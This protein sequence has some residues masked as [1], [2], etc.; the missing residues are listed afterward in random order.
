MVPLKCPLRDRDD[1][2][3][4]TKVVYGMIGCRPTTLPHSG[5]L[6]RLRVD[7]C[8][9]DRHPHAGRTIDDLDLGLHLRAS[10]WTMLVRRP[11]PW[12]RIRCRRHCPKRPAANSSR[13]FRSAPSPQRFGSARGKACFTALMTSSE[14]I[15][16]RLTASDE[17]ASPTADSTFSEITLWSP[18]I[19][20]THNGKILCTAFAV[21]QR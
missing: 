19:G 9:C 16:P 12:R 7:G 6:R 4:S 13:K 15:S 1:T 18:I 3:P 10:T 2:R 5:N 17:R 14:T 21:H 20:G 8:M 11:A